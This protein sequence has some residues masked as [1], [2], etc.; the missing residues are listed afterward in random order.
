MVV[1]VER[2]GRRWRIGSP[3]SSDRTEDVEAERFS[4]CLV[5]SR[6]RSL[7]LL[8]KSLRFSLASSQQ[9]SFWR[10]I[11]WN[12]QQGLVSWGSSLSIFSMTL[13]GFPSLLDGRLKSLKADS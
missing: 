10:N 5:A 2:L 11:N 8:M 13:M 3:G 12:N 6:A 1:K 4:Q 9:S 7:G